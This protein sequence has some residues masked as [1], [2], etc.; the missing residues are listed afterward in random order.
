MKFRNIIYSSL[1]VVCSGLSVAHAATITLNDGRSIEADITGR[2]GDNLILDVNGLEV[3]VDSSQIASVD[4]TTNSAAPDA[5]PVNQDAAANSSN[6]QQVA[7]APPPAAEPAV[8][9][10]GTALTVRMNDSINT[11]SG[12]VGQRFTAILE[13]NLMAGDVVV[14]ERGTTV[15][16]RIIDLKKA[17]RVAGGASMS[18][19]LTEL[20][21]ENQMVP[22]V[23]QPLSAQG[24]NTAATSAGRT[25][26]SAAIGGLAN[27]SSGAKTGA[28]VG[29]GAS[30]LTQGND[31]EL[32]KGT[33]VDFNLRAPLQS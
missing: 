2:D 19:E 20:L 32:P 14:A 7:T 18:I 11:R 9:P 30:L 27:G 8:V 16:G 5:T 23:T 28:K 12:G 29:L 22:I 13:A 1:V 25:A 6:Q 15:Y 26:R 21:I 33:L 10:E 31:I 17:G 4:M 24:Q 3:R